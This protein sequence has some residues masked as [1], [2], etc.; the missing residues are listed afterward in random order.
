MSKTYFFL[1]FLE[2]HHRWCFFYS[3]F[4]RSRVDWLLFIVNTIFSKSFRTW[5]NKKVWRLNNL[6]ILSVRII[7][8]LKLDLIKFRIFSNRIL[9]FN[10]VEI[11]FVMFVIIKHKVINKRWILFDVFAYNF[12]R[13]KM[14]YFTS[15]KFIYFFILFLLFII[16]S[17]LLFIIVFL[18]Q[19]T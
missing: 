16:F 19:K 6:L 8:V 10:S 3:F 7:F 15:L 2:W 9:F 17:L 13:F 5:K 11:I 1:W 4:R 12:N 14:K 18:F